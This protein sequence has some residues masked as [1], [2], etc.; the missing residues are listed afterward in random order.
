VAAGQMIAAGVV[1]SLGVLLIAGGAW[2]VMWN[3]RS[4]FMGPVL[5]FG[6]ALLV[7]GWLL[8]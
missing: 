6:G 1:Q 4:E 5:F 8:G 3:D 2:L 7:T